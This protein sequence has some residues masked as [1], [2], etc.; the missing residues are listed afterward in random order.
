MRRWG[1]LSP[2]VSRST[3][4]S[5]RCRRLERTPLKEPSKNTSEVLLKL[6]STT[7]TTRFLIALIPAL[8]NLTGTAVLMHHSWKDC[9]VP[10]K[11]VSAKTPLS[12][13]P[14][15]SP[16]T[17]TT[18]ESSLASTLFT[19]RAGVAAASWW[20]FQRYLSCVTPEVWLSRITYAA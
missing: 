2:T 6:T 7:S 14:T 17:P 10:S 9:L 4:A 20:H 19:E 1:S 12:P 5:T 3:R 11:G 13:S 18:T 8:Q 16:A 15:M